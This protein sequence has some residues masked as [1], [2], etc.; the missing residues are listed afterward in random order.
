MSVVQLAGA[1]EVS[2][3]TLQTALRTWRS[4][5]PSVFLREARLERVRECLL[6]GEDG[7][8]ITEIAMQAGFMHLGRFSAAYQKKYGENPSAT[9]RKRLRPGRRGT[10]VVSSIEPPTPAKSSPPR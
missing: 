5:T 6:S 2:V 7:R 1:L 9:Q 10:P 8:S 3:R 4:T